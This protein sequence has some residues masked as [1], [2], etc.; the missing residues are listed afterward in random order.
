M[1]GFRIFISNM[2]DEGRNRLMVVFMINKIPEDIIEN[3][4][5]ANDIVDVVG[6]YVQLKKQGRNFFGRCPFH[7]ENTPSFSVTQE[8]QIFYCFGCKKGG[9]VITFLMELEGYS[10]YEAVNFLAE[11]SDI[12]LPA[13]TNSQNSSISSENQSI[14]SAYEWLGKLYHHLLRYTK[15]GKAGYEYFLERGIHE[16]SLETFQLGYAPNVQGFVADF[17]EKK[18]FHQQLLIKAGLLKLQQDNNVIDPFQ[19]RV[20]YPIRNHLG[21]IVAFGG[22]TITDQGPKY[23]NSPEHPLFQKSNILF[24]FDLAKRHIRKDREV[25]LF[26]GQMDVISAYQV[27]VKNVI[28]TLGTSLTENQAKL[29]KR[30]V[31]TVIICY[32]ADRAGLEAS[33][34]AAQLLRQAGCD[35]KIADLK[36]NMDPDSYINKYGAHLF[37][38]EI[39]K[40]SDTYM[41]FYMRYIQ[42]DFNLSIESDK[43]QY[44]QA[45]IKQLAMIESSIEREHYLKELSERFNVSIDSLKEEIK[46]LEKNSSFSKD[47]SDHNRYTKKTIHV[48]QRNRLL[49]AYLN[50]ERVLLAY[51]LQDRF[52]TDRVQKEIGIDFNLEDHKIIATH[53]YGY[54]E[55]HQT[56]DISV[57]IDWL[58]E[59]RLT[60]L[61]I[62]LSMINVF[63]NI[64]EQE[65]NDYINIIQMQSTDMATIQ[66]Y[67]QQQKL[68]EQQNN[69]IKAA[70]IAMKI[71]AIKRQLKNTL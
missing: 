58:K 22:R 52:I 71:I 20:I 63:E 37:N 30:Y 33:Y 59:E 28:A 53:L 4:R 62:E 45:V 25:I 13:I 15:D 66:E 44:I 43:L 17:L 55:A 39:I 23:L 21:R 19:G 54:Y 24:N 6:E 12:E 60:K 34:K 68:A 47:K 5:K 10:F 40:A 42:Q 69:P 35:V 31:D 14:L 29:L 67:R 16:E 65:I 32:D 36:D 3:V 18:G 49:P 7:E 38:D 70:E 11:K 8:K 48:Q 27:G 61:V 46:K 9:N 50:A 51:M 26:E 64:T 57:F 41:S 2:Y 1:Q 56:M